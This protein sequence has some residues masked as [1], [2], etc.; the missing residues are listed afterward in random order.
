MH[1]YN[2]QSSVDSFNDLPTTG[3]TF[4]D[5]RLVIDRG[6]QF[7]WNSIDSDGPITNWRLIDGDIYLRELL[8]VE[9]Y[10]ATVGQVLSKSV[11]GMWKPSSAGSGTVSQSEK[12]NLELELTSSLSNLNA[13]K[14][15]VYTDSVLTTINIYD[16]SN[17]DTLL[18]KK[19]FTYIDEQLTTILITRLSDLATITKTLSYTNGELV[20]ID[21]A[22]D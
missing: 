20:S 21:I 7:F 5:Y 15:F 16:N 13:F 19:E 8:D 11:D 2:Q 18:Y 10:G 1:N 14:E 6:R 17:K 3:N 9:T 4:G 22:V 12:N